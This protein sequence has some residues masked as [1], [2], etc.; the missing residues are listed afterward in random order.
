MGRRT[1]YRV[2]IYSWCTMLLPTV[3]H[4]ELDT[5]KYIGNN[6]WLGD[7]PLAAAAVIIALLSTGVV[8]YLYVGVWELYLYFQPSAGDL[9]KIKN[10]ECLHFT[11]ILLLYQYAT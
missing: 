6:L 10:I 7:W 8:L 4:R 11:T 9:N 3:R 1:F 5:I 2:E